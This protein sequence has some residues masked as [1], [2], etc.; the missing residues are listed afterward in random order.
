MFLA[1]EN[2]I[3]KTGRKEVYAIKLKLV[4]SAWTC[5]SKYWTYQVS[6]QQ[7]IYV[8]WPWDRKCIF[9]TSLLCLCWKQQPST[10]LFS[11]TTLTTTL[12]SLSTTGYTKDIYIY[13]RAFSL[14]SIDAI[15]KI[16]DLYW[17]RTTE[18]LPKVHNF[19]KDTLLESWTCSQIYPRIMRPDLRCSW[20]ELDSQ[21]A[22]IH[23]GIRETDLSTS[24]TGTCPTHLLRT[25]CGPW[26]PRF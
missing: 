12:L 14:T 4:A 3:S 19:K 1:W 20:P 10:Q 24:T 13:L 16:V 25:E 8:L 11:S 5:F 6:T 7:W 9:S 17:K 26:G 21:S 23:L 18:S 2:F 22:C 15:V